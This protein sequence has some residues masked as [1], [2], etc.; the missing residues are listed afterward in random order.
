MAPKTV[1]NIS[2]NNNA[3][4]TDVGLLIVA[5]KLA[6]ANTNAAFN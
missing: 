3:N 4:T 5:I 6:F 1:T 2:G